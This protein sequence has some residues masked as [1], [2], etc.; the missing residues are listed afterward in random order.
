MRQRSINQT[1]NER[2]DALAEPYPEKSHNLE[3]V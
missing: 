2:G 1:E 3:K